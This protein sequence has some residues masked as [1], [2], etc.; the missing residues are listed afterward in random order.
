MRM[1]AR[2]LDIPG[3]TCTRQYHCSL[4]LCLTRPGEPS[5]FGA[6]IGFNDRTAATINAFPYLCSLSLSLDW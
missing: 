2:D 1:T 4:C 6:F 3:Y 5:C